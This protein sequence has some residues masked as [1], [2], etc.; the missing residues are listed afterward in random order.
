M[1]K[2]EIAQ[3]REIMARKEA[4]KDETKANTALNAM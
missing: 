4:V 2:R 3:E 1:D